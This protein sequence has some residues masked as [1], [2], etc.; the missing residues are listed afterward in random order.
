M[1]WFLGLL[2]GVIGL[3]GLHPAVVLA[4]FSPAK[5]LASQAFPRVTGARP[6]RQVL[7]GGQFILR[8]GSA[9]VP[10]I[11]GQT[12][13]AM[14]YGSGYAQME[15]HANLLLRLYAQARGRAAAYWGQP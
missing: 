4:R 2:V 1:G 7:I 15:N 9:G 8:Q 6:I 13:P 10:H 12:L 14:Y 3:S 11:Y 5:A